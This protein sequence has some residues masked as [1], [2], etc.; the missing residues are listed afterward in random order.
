MINTITIIGS[1]QTPSDVLEL[2][3]H[4]ATWCTR[5]GIVVR[6]GKAGGADAAAIYGC[7]KAYEQSD[8][9][10]VPEMYIPWAGFGETGMSTAWDSV[11]GSNVHAESIASSIHPAWYKCSQGAKKLHTRNVCQILGVNL[12]K[13]SDVV[14]YWCKEVG[15]KPTGGTATAVNLGTRYGCKCINML[16]PIWKEE[17]R[18]SLR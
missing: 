7:M 10:A 12:D 15:G 17:L 8:I 1:R 18:E 4:I 14:L 6:S 16:R 5:K 3:E 2:M 11:Q 9:V 13:P